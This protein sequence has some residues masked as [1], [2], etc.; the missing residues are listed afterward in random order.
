MVN[1][2]NICW[3]DH[4]N[5]YMK[6]SCLQHTPNEVFD[7]V[8][9]ALEHQ[10]DEE[11]SL[12]TNLGG[13]CGPLLDCTEIDEYLKVLIIVRALLAAE[14]SKASIRKVKELIREEKKHGDHDQY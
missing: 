7:A 10:S 2:R 4:C 14:K 6:K 13:I 12:A 8:K 3:F 1:V 5:V 9:L 11:L